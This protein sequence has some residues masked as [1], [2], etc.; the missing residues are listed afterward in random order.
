MH[1]TGT[2]DKVSFT[3]PLQNIPIDFEAKSNSRTLNVEE[4]QDKQN[5]VFTVLPHASDEGFLFNVSITNAIEDSGYGYYPYV[6]S[7]LH[8][9]M[10]I[11]GVDKISTVIELPPGTSPYSMLTEIRINNNKFVWGSREDVQNAI[12]HYF[13]GDGKTIQVVLGT[14]STVLDHHARIKLCIPFRM[15][16]NLLP[17]IVLMPL[18]I[19]LPIIII[20]GL[21][22]EIAS[23]LT[24]VY[25]MLT[26]FPL[27]LAVWQRN[28]QGSIHALSYI[29]VL[30]VFSALIWLGYALYFNLS[31][32]WLVDSIF[33]IGILLPYAVW[34]AYNLGLLVWFRNKP[35]KAGVVHKPF[36]LFE[37][38]LSFMVY[39]QDK[40]THKKR[41]EPQA[42]KIQDAI[43]KIAHRYRTKVRVPKTCY[44][45]EQV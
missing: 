27:L 18:L 5:H 12:G 25:S 39:I 29:N 32:S 13:K 34:F 15:R 36:I 35:T 4:K 23:F 38:S 8:L 37:Y 24:K 45:E 42:L 30:W 20:W 40:L 7:L 44:E 31:K 33:S 1:F 28:T 21:P 6:T 43:D 19:G 16:S 9:Q 17:G 2:A 22:E 3:F 41:L 10:I 11:E 14:R 26:A